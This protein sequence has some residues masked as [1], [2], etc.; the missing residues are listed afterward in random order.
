[1]HNLDNDYFDKEMAFTEMR[2]EFY[3]TMKLMVEPTTKSFFNFFRRGQYVST[4]V[5]LYYD[6]R[7]DKIFDYVLEQNLLPEDLTWKLLGYCLYWFTEEEI[8]EVRIPQT[9]KDFAIPQLH[10]RKLCIKKDNDGIYAVV[11]LE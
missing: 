9:I 4:D 5:E 8:K 3:K 11:F 6:E 1:M 7:L 10:G 2:N